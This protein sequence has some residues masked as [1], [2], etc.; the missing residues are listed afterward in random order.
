MN[1]TWQ[2]HI[3]RLE[4]RNAELEHKLELYENLLASAMNALAEAMRELA[5][6]HV[7]H[8]IAR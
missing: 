1:L 7:S 3:E 8:G 6:Q 4:T 2:S 5:E